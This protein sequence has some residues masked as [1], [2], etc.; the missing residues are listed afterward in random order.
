MNIH[1]SHLDKAD[2]DCSDHDE[3]DDCVGDVD[4]K[5]GNQLKPLLLHQRE[6]ENQGDGQRNLQTWLSKYKILRC[7]IQRN[8]GG[9]FS[10]VGI[11]FST[12]LI[13]GQGV[14]QRVPIPSRSSPVGGRFSPGPPL[15]PPWQ[16]GII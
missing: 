2:D 13:P 10:G 16:T 12:I 8:Y 6:I 5:D 4:N 11:Q 15:R 9:T 14:P 1:S 7:C 3:V